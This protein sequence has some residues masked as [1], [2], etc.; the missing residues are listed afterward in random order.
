MPK[1]SQSKQTCPEVC[2]TRYK[3]MFENSRDG[4]VMIDLDR[5]ITNVNKAFCKIVGYPKKELIGLDFLK[6]TPKK[7]HEWET[8][9]I[10]EKRLKKTGYTGVYEKEYIKKD[11]SI[12]PVELSSFTVFDKNKNPLY[13]WGSVRDISKR[14]AAET[15]LSEKQDLLRQVEQI[16]KIGGWEMDIQTGQATWTRGTYDIVEIEPGQPVPG[17]NEHVSFYLPEYQGMISQAM[18]DLIKRDVPLDFKAHLKTAKGNIKWCHAVGHAV[19]EGGKCVKVQG[20]FQD[21]TD[22]KE[23]KDKIKKKITSLEQAEKLARL[24]NFERNW[25]TGKGYWSKGFYRLLG[26]KS[27]SIESTHKNFIKHVHKDDLDRVNKHVKDTL[28]K[29]TDM[30]IEFRIVQHTGGIIYVHGLGKNIYDKGGK[31]L[32]TIGVFKDITEQKLM[33][34]TLQESE[35]QFRR[36]FEKA[37]NPIVIIDNKG[38]F[39]QVNPASLEITGYTKEQ[40]ENMTVFD[41]VE[42]EFHEN[43]MKE[44]QNVDQ[45]VYTEEIRYKHSSGESRWCHVDAVTFSSQASLGFITDIHNEKE[46]AIKVKQTN[47]LKS[48]LISALKHISSE[49]M[50]KIKWSL[51]TLLQ[52]NL[53]ELN[54]KQKKFLQNSLD[55]YSKISHLISDI[56][57]LVDFEQ[58]AI[59]PD[60]NNLA[61]RDL[62]SKEV[63]NFQ[64][65]CNLRKITCKF[66]PPESNIRG[67]NADATLITHTIRHLLQNSILYSDQGGKVKIS[68]EFKQDMVRIT[69]KDEGRGI[70]KAEQKHIFDMFYRGSNIR[71]INPDGLGIGLYLAKRIVQAHNGEIGFTSKE[72][73]GSTFWFEIPIK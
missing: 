15:E 66:T 3:E 63:V 32:Y 42:P 39:K 31:P 60:K 40:L 24:G 14:K 53:G 25:K 51:R 44:L 6:I 17:L 7:W 29:K 34:N 55:D 11:G 61:I 73:K 12:V 70:P 62:I 47:L 9:E 21:I 18:N 23:A 69:V 2:D 41:L 22:Q 27:D 45:N 54:N 48:R 56:G 59:Q 33:L 13:M 58:S 43:I 57:L 65:E 38:R 37:P 67:I 64:P 28:K 35:E 20:T 46:A 4:F 5:K 52:E 36:M 71:T 26:R 72:G 1:K 49:P 10:V 19:R 8:K 68:M 16:A 50:E 30:D